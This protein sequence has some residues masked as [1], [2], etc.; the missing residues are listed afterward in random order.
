M[1]CFGRGK[2]A[3]AHTSND[4]AEE[5]LLRIFRGTGPSGSGGMAVQT[6]DNIVRPLLFA[7][8][9]EILDYLESCNFSFREDASNLEPFCQRNSLRLNLFPILEK[10]FHGSIVEVLTRHADLVRDEESFW[11]DQ[12]R[13]YWKTIC[14]EESPSRL[15]LKTSELSA[16]PT[17]LRRRTLRYALGKLQ[18]DLSGIYAVHIEALE[19]LL[20]RSTSGKSIHLPKGMR[21][22]KECRFIT[23]SIG[24]S[25]AEEFSRNPWDKDLVIERPGVYEFRGFD[26][27]VSVQRPTV[28]IIDSIHVHSPYRA[29]MDADRIT[30]PL[31]V[32]TWKPGDRFQPLGSYGTKKLQDFFTDSKIPRGQRNQIPLLCDSEKI[33]WIMGLRLD[34]GVKVTPETQFLIIVEG[35]PSAKQPS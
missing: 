17:A 27:Q 7:Q 14:V 16:L 18:G 21:A 15:I 23:I 2:L 19:R 6:P 8:R 26:L 20:E 10:I 5:V 24:Q 34:E 1:K 12:V 30:W 13:H 32:R 25:E 22:A 31:I 4:Q 11:V 35:H 3:L 33:C 28:E 29:F 9:A